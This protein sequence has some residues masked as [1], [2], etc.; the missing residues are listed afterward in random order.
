[1][2]DLRKQ[3][4]MEERKCSFDECGNPYESRGYCASHARQLR[5]GFELRPLRAYAR[6]GCSIKGC[7]DPHQALGYCNR[8]HLRVRNHGD[9]QHERRP[10]S[11]PRKYKL[12]VAFFDEIVTEAQAYWLG[13]IT[14]DG[15]I[16]QTGRTN[17]LRVGLHPRD[18][19]HLARMN[20]DLGSDRPLLRYP[21]KPSVTAAFDSLHLVNAL[22]T[23]GVG[24][25]KSITVKPW[26]GPGHL[27]PHYWRGMFDGDGSI[28]PT[29]ARNGWCLS[30]CGSEFCVRTFASWA[31][32]TCGS[33]AT[34][35]HLKGGCW[36]WRVGGGPRP[37]RLARALYGEATVSL[38]R[39]QERADRLITT[40]FQT[41]GR[42]SE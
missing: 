42:Q 15:G 28:F 37:Q 18:E 14:A 26:S 8:H 29:I 17:T 1:M 32:G 24:P 13:F 7:P 9:A 6:E 39:K 16:T 5:Q 33:T 11:A 25:R 30:I 2:D 35:R 36:G 40:A 19:G 23:L 22:G 10:E 4:D 31:S 12:N 38:A 34:P 41:S 27:M 3:I 20:A 21:T